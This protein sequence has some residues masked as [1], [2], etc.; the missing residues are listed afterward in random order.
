[1]HELLEVIAGEYGETHFRRSKMEFEQRDFAPPSQPL[2]VS[3]EI[4]MT[5]GVFLIAPP[6]WDDAFHAAPRK[7]LAVVLSGAATVAATDGE[8]VALQAG[9]FLLLNDEGSKGH[10]TQVQGTE[11]FCVLLVGL[12]SDDA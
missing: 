9:D 7:Q 11:N 4:P 5:A 6:G 1:M 3:N 8:I 12:E 10:L 2:K